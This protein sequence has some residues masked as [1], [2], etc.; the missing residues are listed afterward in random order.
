[1]KRK[2]NRGESLIETMFALLVGSM[3]VMLLATMISASAKLIRL[4][5]ENADDYTI[6]LN[7]MNSPVSP[8][9][10]TVTDACTAEIQFD[11]DG[12]GKIDAGD[13]GDT[14]A[15]KI[16]SFRDGGSAPVFAYEQDTGNT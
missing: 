2:A 3:S 10:V 7:E 9:K 15:V 5:E 16:K 13:T 1:M 14:V 6:I 12:D 11:S 8:T 4:G